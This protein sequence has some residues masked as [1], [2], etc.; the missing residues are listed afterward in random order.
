MN[1]DA[2]HRFIVAEKSVDFCFVD[3]GSG[4]GTAALLEEFVAAHRERSRLIAVGSNRGKAEAV[5]SG[6]CA[7]LENGPFDLIGYFDADLSAPLSAISG[8]VSVFSRKKRCRFVLGSRFRH[9]GVRIVRSNVRHYLG[10]VF[11]TLSSM[12]LDLPVYDTQC[13]AKLLRTETARTLFNE[14]FVSRWLFDVELLARMIV[15]YGRLATLGSVVELPLREWDERKGSRLNWLYAITVPF[16][17][18]KIKKRYFPR[19]KK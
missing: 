18:I 15:H 7:S 3:D 4:D 14:P 8:F 11:S 9:M 5:R 16:E 13:G 17:L 6:V 1:L 19:K 10:R 2:F 12:L